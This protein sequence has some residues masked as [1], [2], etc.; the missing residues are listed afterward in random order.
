MQYGTETRKVSVG[1]IGFQKN[2]KKEEEIRNKGNGVIVSFRDKC[3]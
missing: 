1:H 3:T 2:V